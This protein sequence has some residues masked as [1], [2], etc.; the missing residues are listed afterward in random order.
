MNIRFKIVISDS[1]KGDDEQV[2][3]QADDHTE[4]H[5]GFGDLR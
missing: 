4:F 3:H 2:L 1:M 5:F